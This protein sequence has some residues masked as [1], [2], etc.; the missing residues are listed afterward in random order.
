MNHVTNQGSKQPA[1]PDSPRSA[2]ARIRQILPAV[3]LA[4]FFVFE[5]LALQ[6]LVYGALTARTG[7]AVLYG[8]AA[9]VLLWLVSSLGG[10][11]LNR[12]IA[13]L[14]V[15]I[16][17]VLFGVQYVYHSVFGNF[18]SLGQVSMGGDV[19]T[20]FRDQ[21][22]YGIR[23]A[24]GPLAVLI[25]PL[26]LT[27]AL[28]F[29][30][31][32]KLRRANR[33]G[34]LTAV[35]VFAALHGAAWAVMYGTAQGAYSV[36]RV[37][38]GAN[39]SVD[40]S[41][42]SVGLLATMR[43]E[44]RYLLFGA[45]E[46][47]GGYILDEGGGSYSSDDYNVLDIDFAALADSTDDETLKR[48]DEYMAAAA[49]T[50]KNRYTGLLKGYNLIT[51]CAESFS[52]YLIDPERTPA[53]YQLSTNGFVFENY[54]GSFGSVTTDGEYT[55]CMGL[56]P[57]ASRDKYQAS[58]RQTV[59][60][61]LPFCLGNAFRALGADTWAYHNYYGEYY[62][63]EY[64]HSN[65]G[66][67]FKT[68]SSG[69][70]VEVQWPSSDLEMM[71][72]S[73]D[74][75]LESG[76]QFHAYY[77]TFSGHYQYNWDNP[78]SAKNR[79]MAEDL[80]YSE[81][82]QAYIACNQEL[83]YALE[84]LLERLE[85]AGVADRTVIVLTNDHYPYGLTEE[86][87]NELAGHEVDTVFERYRNS[88]ICY[89]PNLRQN[90]TV[91][92]Y[93]STEDI[94]PTLLNLFG[95]PYDS[96]MLAGRDVLA[97]CLHMAVLS[98]QSIIT[99]R[100]RFDAATNTVTYTGGEEDPELVAQCQALVQN[101]FQVS[102]DILNSDYYRHV[103]PDYEQP[104]TPQTAACPF[105]DLDVEN[106]FY[107]P[108]IMSWYEQG[109]V[110]PVSETEFGLARWCTPAEFVETL[111]RVVG[112]PAAEGSPP[113]S[114]ITQEHPY[115]AAVQWAYENGLLPYSDG[116]LPQE[117]GITRKDAALVLWRWAASLGED[118]A[119]DAGQLA[120]D[121]ADYPDF[122]EAELT[123]L[124]WAF[125]H[126]IL[127]GDGTFEGMMSMSL[128]GLTRCYGIDVINRFLNRE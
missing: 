78:M 15:L 46:G 118:V 31:V 53:L 54:Y 36:Y 95:L 66:Y 122:T 32:L 6:L 7:Y 97:D 98:D 75:Y 125:E 3:Y 127:R 86:E 65:M 43:Q 13:F 52:P 91:D 70:D 123:A 90:V 64:T 51:I 50:G 106:G 102:T 113:Y 63:R 103:L 62:G 74:D 101:R 41:V 9:G 79:E 119:V 87:Y 67:V 73:V 12:V 55:M 68:P 96:R 4:A 2:G 59:G 58:F 37:Y 1:G 8:T 124:R 34:I 29:T 82:V 81:T 114:N 42:R 84:Y 117:T 99:E 61:A 20:N 40:T 18:M 126:A 57:D 24:A 121:C 44:A 72:A 115:F 11:R 85:E 110:D 111:Y 107:K 69:L 23:Q 35:L 27:A 56:F 128:I 89:V 25:A 49:A 39:S 92:A 16:G 116:E 120:Q 48:L 112:R 22:F 60:H 28:L 93:C 100:F 38:T 80:P 83:E 14:G 45:P 5:E 33:W 26:V 109:Y 17:T 88:F 105:T 19:L 71:M 94:L 30:R 77:M 76:G 108:L 104:D 47:D 10:E 21:L